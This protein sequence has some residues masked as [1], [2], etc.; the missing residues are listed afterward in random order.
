MG[1]K[2]LSSTS[3]SADDIGGMVIQMNQDCTSHTFR[4]SVKVSSFHADQ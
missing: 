2:I 4:R 1:G 3:V